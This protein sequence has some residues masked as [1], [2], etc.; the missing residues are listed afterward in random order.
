MINNFSFPQVFNEVECSYLTRQSFECGPYGFTCQGANKIRLCE[1]NTLFGPTF[2]C[3]ANTICNEDSNEVCENAFNYIDPSLT[4]AFKCRRNERIADPNVADCKGYILCIPNKNR[5]QGIKFKCAG[6]TIFNGISRTCSSP[7]KYKC[8]LTSTSKPI[9]LYESNRRSDIG[10]KFRY[11]E[12]NSA[13]HK[14]RPIDCKNYRF[15]VTQEG[16]S[17]AMYFCPRIPARGDSATRCTVFSNHFCITLERDD[18]DQFA[19]S[20]GVANRSPRINK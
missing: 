12:V 1:G 5:I 7:E 11:D 19:L 16:P 6:N 18:E 17:K 13:A 15:A 4:K 14:V 3:P 10:T 2:L 20:S 9:E 8:P